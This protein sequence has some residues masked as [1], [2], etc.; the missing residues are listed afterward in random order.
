MT[1]ADDQ[2]SF[3]GN[4]GRNAPT[5][6]GGHYGDQAPIPSGELDG[7]PSMPRLVDSWI[8]SLRT[9]RG[10]GLSLHTELAYRHDLAVL[11]RVAGDLLGRAPLTAEELRL[12]GPGRERLQLKRVS[13]ADFTEA[14]IELVIARLLADPK[15][16]LSSSSRARYLSAWRSF[17]RWAVRNSL[18]N[19]DP[20]FEFDLASA[21]PRDPVYFS[22][23]DLR[24]M[25]VVAQQP[26]IGSSA[27]WPIRDVALIAVLAGSGIRASELTSLTTSGLIREGNPRLHVVGKG[28]KDRAVPVGDEVV[29]H[30]DAYLAERLERGLGG[31]LPDDW[32][33][34]RTDGRPFDTASLDRR[35]KAW[36]VAAGVTLRPG[37]KAH[38]F[39]HTYAVGQLLNGTD[40]ATLRQLLGHE[41]LDTT[42]RYLRMAASELAGAGRAAPVLA[43]LREL[44]KPSEPNS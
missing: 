12:P 2:N 43:L 19:R 41:K 15:R 14:T 26:T 16:P 4:P 33:F 38:A 32:L 39:R 9:R 13:L 8:T 44:R 20:T 3:P 24:R 28:G 17:S 5:G 22:E 29:E 25:L 31:K 10:R 40:I 30:I 27:R 37:E 1:T 21:S 11:A 18:L 34:V 35:V 36:M 42:A 23:E 6:P 7:E